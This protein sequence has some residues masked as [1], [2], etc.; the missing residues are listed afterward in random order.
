MNKAVREVSRAASRI[1]VRRRCQL[2]RGTSGQKNESL[3][4]GCPQLATG[5]KSTHHFGP[6]SAR[7]LHYASPITNRVVLELRSKHG[8][9]SCS[10]ILCSPMFSSTTLAPRRGAGRQ[11]NPTRSSIRLA[12]YVPV[13]AHRAGTKPTLRYKVGITAPFSPGIGFLTP[14]VQV[15]LSRMPTSRK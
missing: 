8:F 12:K 7:G 3:M 2:A 11:P 13:P 4:A 14:T 1:K 15:R 5:S 6:I 9:L 10:T